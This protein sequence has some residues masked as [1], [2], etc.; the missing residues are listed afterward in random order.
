M[1]V[2]S[3]VQT[4]VLRLLA[5]TLA[6]CAAAPA[7]ASA[8]VKAVESCGGFFGCIVTVT[9]VATADDI[10]ISD[11]PDN[12]EH[13]QFTAFGDS[14]A[15]AWTVTFDVDRRG[16]GRL[17]Q[18][19]RQQPAHHQV[20]PRLDIIV[21]DGGSG[22]DDFYTTK[23][24]S[25]VR[26]VGGI[27]DDTLNSGASGSFGAVLDGGDGDDTIL[28]SEL[29]D[30]AVGG[31]GADVINGY[32]GADD[33]DGE[34]GDDEIV[35]GSGDD[36]LKGG[37]GRD[38]LTPG[39]GKDQVNGGTGFDGVLY[40]E[41]TNRVVVTL[42][43]A[44]NDG[45]AGENDNVKADV[46]DVTG[47]RGDDEL[48]GN[49]QGNVLDGRAGNDT[50]TGG[51][52]LDSYIAGDGDDIVKARDGQRENIDCG[53]GTDV[54]TGDQIDQLFDCETQDLSADLVAD[55]DGDGFTKPGDC[56]DTNPGIRPNAADTPDNGVDENCDGADSVNLDRDGDG[57]ARPADCDDANRNVRP[58][59]P[60]I[61]GNSVDEDCSQFADPFPSITATVPSGF[62]GFARYTV[63]DMLRVRNAPAGARVK[64]TCKGRGCPKRSQSRK[65]SKRVALLSIQKPFKRRRLGIGARIEVSI[66]KPNHIGRVVRFTMRRRNVP[67]SA[68]LCLPPG[69]KKATEC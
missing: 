36:T 24:N 6:L 45:E 21:V 2:S 5:L 52:G 35:G 15:V 30:T 23:S 32:G 39:T 25:I 51:D 69:A 57:V 38:L 44:A 26:L 66:T 10:N 9:G 8:E 14:G 34:S 68:S 50:L 4:S 12:I 48:T 19:G 55:A 40:S 43:D 41:R 62:T 67:T 53:G 56:N 49:A 54:A 18:P 59:V 61:L 13:T 33:I 37:S 28:G 22:N 17:L 11:N 58:G 46:E 29:N 47:G 31:A 65:L 1:L 20:Q 3:P 27:G 63:V 60:E 64:V 42:D 7:A 16:R